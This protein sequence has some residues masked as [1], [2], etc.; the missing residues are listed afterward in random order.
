MIESET[1]NLETLG[2]ILFLVLWLVALALALVASLRYRK[3]GIPFSELK[4][5]M[6]GLGSVFEGPGLLLMRIA[7][8]LAALGFIALIA[9]ASPTDF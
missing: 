7:W 4:I 1:N 3:P 2:R 9:T 6:R 5:M 8:V